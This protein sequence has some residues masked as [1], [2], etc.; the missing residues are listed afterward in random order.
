MS[1]YGK[2]PTSPPAFTPLLLVPVAHGHALSVC[3][4]HIRASSDVVCAFEMCFCVLRFLLAIRQYKNDA[5]TYSREQAVQQI[6][7]ICNKFLNSD[8]V[9]PVTFS[10]K[11]VQA[12]KQQVERY[13]CRVCVFVFIRTAP[14]HAWCARRR[15]R[16]AALHFSPSI[17]FA[18]D[19]SLPFFLCVCVRIESGTFDS[20]TTLFDRAL[21]QVTMLLVRVC[22]REMRLRKKEKESELVLIL[23][24]CGTNT[25][26]TSSQSFSL[27]FSLMC[28]CFLY[29]CSRSDVGNWLL[30]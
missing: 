22:E 15:P 10:D 14:S 28:S 19:R 7:A 11:Q 29:V 30:S 9:C 21:A 20:V 18:H 3:Q 6:R 16:T 26:W 5:A 8:C 12:I 2:Y 17:T 23:S 25:P 24:E 27:E 13:C 4:C 1:P